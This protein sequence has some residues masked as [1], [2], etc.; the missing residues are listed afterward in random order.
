[1]EPR[2]GKAAF[3]VPHQFFQREPAHA[4]DEAA[5]DLSAVDQRRE[6][7]ADILQQIGAQHAVLAGEAIDL[8]FRNGRAVREVV[9]RPA[10]R[11][12]GS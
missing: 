8:D 12:F 10:L 7:L 6:A 11:V 4:L 9:E 2:G 5:F 3:R 1:M